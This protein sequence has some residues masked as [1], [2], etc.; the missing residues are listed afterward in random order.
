MRS[1]LISPANSCNNFNSSVITFSKQKRPTISR[2]WWCCR[3]SH[4]ASFQYYENLNTF[5]LSQNPKHH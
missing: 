1:V 3:Y 5:S 4:R 2:P